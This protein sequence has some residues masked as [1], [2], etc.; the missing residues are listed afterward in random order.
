MKQ[1]IVVLLGYYL[2]F[3]GLSLIA[4]LFF[5]K[6]SLL[7]KIISGLAGAF[8]IW[9]GYLTR[10][11]K[12]ADSEN[13]EVAKTIELRTTS[14]QKAIDIINELKQDSS[15][16]M[17]KR[18]KNIIKKNPTDTELTHSKKDGYWALRVRSGELLNAIEELNNNQLYQNPIKYEFKDKTYYFVLYLIDKK[19]EWV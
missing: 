19:F 4:M 8:F 15:E 16:S 18:F 6:M 7:L 2:I 10:Q 13:I 14:K 12:G 3:Q 5:L 1:L 11:E 9:I 17:E